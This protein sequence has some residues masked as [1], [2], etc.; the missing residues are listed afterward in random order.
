VV[1]AACLLLAPT[2]QGQFRLGV[3]LAL[4]TFASVVLCQFV[5]CC[6]AAGSLEYV[7]G[8]IAATAGGAAFAMLL[9]RLVWPW[10]R[11]R[12]AMEGCSHAMQ[13][14]VRAAHSMYHEEYDRIAALATHSMYHEEYDRIAA[15]AMGGS[16]AAAPRTALELAASTSASSAGGGT[17][18]SGVGR[19]PGLNA[20]PA[21]GGAA[22][23]SMTAPLEGCASPP[24]CSCSASMQA[25]VDA[26]LLQ[27]QLL[28]IL[29]PVQVSV[30]RD[31]WI[32]WKRG[33]LALAPVS[34]R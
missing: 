14:A 9:M 22:A 10:Y 21:D 1:V 5:G 18:S 8:R 7:A 4:L 32:R 31:T 3:V 19:P 20:R 30:A 12:W 33:R 27:R 15:L 34:G 17:G 26:Q 2:A 29:M 11:N 28:G 13:L 25:P 24:A 16:A 23:S 6:G